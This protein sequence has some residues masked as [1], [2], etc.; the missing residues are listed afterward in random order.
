MPDHNMV[1]AMSK[2]RITK[3]AVKEEVEAA[4]E[5]PDRRKKH[6]DGVTKTV[7]ASTL[8]MLSG[9]ICFYFLAPTTERPENFSY[10]LLLLAFYIQKPIY[11]QLGMD[12]A[13]FNWKDWF[14]IAFM[15]LM[16]WFITWTLLLN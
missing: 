10:L 3:N 4:I 9:V 6:I 5:K 8:G 11:M 7:I 13:Q 1:V 2:K 12:V 15:T 14:Y 16:L